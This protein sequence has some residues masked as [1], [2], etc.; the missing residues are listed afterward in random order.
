MFAS[1]NIPPSLR[2]TWQR[3]ELLETQENHP[4]HNMASA[5]AIVS[6]DTQANGGWKMEDVTVRDPGEGELLV[7]IIAS[8]VCHTDVLIGGLPAG[9]APIAFY[10]R[11]LGHEGVSLPFVVGRLSLTW[12][13][14][15]WICKEGRPW[16]YCRQR[17]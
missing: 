7:E 5:K 8:G 2:A 16:R 13:A 15:K 14:R 10:P 17:G 6:R 3:L 12:Y 4:I 1:N 11:V 9:A